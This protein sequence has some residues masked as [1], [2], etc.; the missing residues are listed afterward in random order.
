MNT[1]IFA[2]FL[3]A[4]GTVTGSKYLIEGAGK[5]IL[6]DCG[7]FQGLK[8]LRL[9][10]WNRLPVDA[11]QIDFVLLT[12]AH[13]DHTG[14][15]PCLVKAGFRGKIYGTKPT[16]ALAE[17][18][19]K[20]S[21]KIQEEEAEQA[22]RLGYS[23]HK[24][25][26]ALYDLTDV[27]KT[28]SRFNEIK[29]DEWIRF[30]HGV[31]VRYQ[32]NGHII[33]SAFIELQIAEKRI[34]FSGDVGQ[35]SDVLM[36]PPKRPLEAD[37]LFVES[38]YG[39]RLHVKENSKERLQNIILETIKRGGTLII[40]S[41]VVERTQTLMYLTWQLRKAGSI[42]EIP[43]IIDSP[44]G[45]NV[46]NVFHISEQWYKISQNDCMEMCRTFKVIKDYKE[47]MEYVST[48]FPKII[49]AGSG[50]VTGGRVLTYLQ[51]YI[52]KPETTVLL[53]GFQAEGTRGRQLLE[54]TH[55]IKMY[56]KYYP[57]KAKIETLNSISAHGDQQ[58][59]LN[60]M[61]E[62]KEA[63][64]KVFIVH[65]EKHA[66]DAFRVKIEDTYEWNA[67]TPKLYEIHELN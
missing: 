37:I 54:G 45:A 66:A 7:L 51:H 48:S 13:L 9:L 23:R 25:A 63:P 59:L 40:P 57:V 43:C 16:L 20:D 55:E 10:N 26:K 8:E 6:V 49:I 53:A 61:S 21:A 2:H 24:P 17:I 29:V 11:S 62:I 1:K 50:M 52:G 12:H 65:G 30:D 36:Y 60:W 38:T 58:D 44:M 56:G 33:G 41:F 4:A 31:E 42:P 32:M 67:F 27:E 46:L 35:E 15:L 28:I 64:E 18:I 5:K 3:G 39:D 14:Y 19:L 47:T 34:V 22:N